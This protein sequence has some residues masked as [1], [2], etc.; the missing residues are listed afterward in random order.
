MLLIYERIVRVI[1]LAAVAGLPWVFGGVE[2][3]YHLALAIL[4]LPVLL[5]TL[6]RFTRIAAAW[7]AV[8][9]PL[10]LPDSLRLQYKQSGR[11]NCEIHIPA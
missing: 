2:P 11:S 7:R 8:A 4:L 9:V 5:V 10:L 1:L 6:I 3:K